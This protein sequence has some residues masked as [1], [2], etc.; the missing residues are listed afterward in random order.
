MLK[1]GVQSVV[2]ETMCVFTLSRLENTGN[3][4]R[5]TKDSLWKIRIQQKTE[6]TLPQS[7]KQKLNQYVTTKADLDRPSQDRGH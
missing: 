7:Q 4:K 3:V 6:N 5:K 1:A 2:V